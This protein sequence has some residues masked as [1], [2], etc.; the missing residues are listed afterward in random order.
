MILQESITSSHQSDSRLNYLH[1][2]CVANEVSQHRYA[3]LYEPE[4]T[5]EVEL[6]EDLEKILRLL[7]DKNPETTHLRY[8][9]MALILALTVKPAIDYYFPDRAIAEK[10]IVQLA[11]WLVEVIKQVPDTENRASGSLGIQEIEIVPERIVA[12]LSENRKIASFQVLYEALDVYQN[13]V[14]MLDRN[15]SLEALLEI[16]EDC[17]EGYA[18]FPGASG[19]RELF[20]WWL[21]DVVPASLQLR[22]PASIYQVENSSSGEASAQYLLEILN[23]IYYEMK[24]AI[25]RLP[26]SQ[27]SFNRYPT[28]PNIPTVAKP[29]AYGKI[30]TFLKNENCYLDAVKK[31]YQ[32][33]I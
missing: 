16:L 20:N 9:W 33:K 24:F 31:Y 29:N 30:N 1:Y 2:L 10:T 15:K 19:R 18:I 23:R 26:E 6:Q 13:A 8:V 3:E 5:G 28:K 32:I 27:A 17:L 7:E 11:M 21:R 12:S 25:A 14:K 4:A 22:P